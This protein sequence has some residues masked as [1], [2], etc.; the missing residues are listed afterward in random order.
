MKREFHSNISTRL[1]AG[2]VRALVVG[3]LLTWLAHSADDMPKARIDWQLPTFQKD[4][5]LSILDL[6]GSVLSMEDAPAGSKGEYRGSDLFVLL[7]GIASLPNLADAA[8]AAHRNEMVGGVV[9]NACGDELV[10]RND[11]ALP[12]EIVVLACGKN[13]DVEIFFR[14]SN[15]TQSRL[16]EAVFR[17]M[18]HEK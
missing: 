10:I 8:I 6:E 18:E 11:Q 3:F 15:P 9:I 5:V 7:K 1:H 14:E 4:V 17:V 16:V 12:R 13:N 2:L